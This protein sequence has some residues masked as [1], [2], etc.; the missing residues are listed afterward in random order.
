M[1][2]F[3]ILSLMGLVGVIAIGIAALR[4]PS[5]LWA[6]GLF[7]LAILACLAS[8]IY[9]IYSKGRRRAFGVGFAICGWVNL[10]LSFAPGFDN[11]VAPHLLTT[12]VLDG[13]YA[14]IV[15]PNPA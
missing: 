13:L 10:T 5:P 7:T 15:P 2:R 6:N 1:K 3:S 4:S 14:R 11:Q 9:A 12:A 8:V